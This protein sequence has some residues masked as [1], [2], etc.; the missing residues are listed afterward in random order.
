MT[1]VFKRADFGFQKSARSR[2]NDT[3]L[4]ERIL[5]LPPQKRSFP[6]R[7]SSVNVT[8]DIKKEDFINTEKFSFIESF[9]LL[10]IVTERSPY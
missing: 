4:T 5:T 2:E 7:V 6:L 3:F 8:N 10:T 1:F 9:Q